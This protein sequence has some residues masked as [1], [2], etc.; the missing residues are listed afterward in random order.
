MTS[1]LLTGLVGYWK[2]DETSGP[3]INDEVGINDGQVYNATINQTGKIGKA[4]S[5]DGSGDYIRCATQ[6]WV[7]TGNFSITAWINITSFGTETTVS[8]I[9]TSGTETTNAGI[10]FYCYGDGKL[11]CDLANSAG[12]VSTSTLSTGTWYLVGVTNNGGTFQLYINGSAD[13]S[14]TSKSPNIASGYQRFG[15]DVATGSNYINGLIDEVGVWSKALTPTEFTELYNLGTGI[16]YP[17][18]TITTI[19]VSTP[20]D[21]PGAGTYSSTQSVTLSCATSGASIYYTTDGSTP[22]ATKTLYTGAFNISVTTTLKA[23]GIKSGY[24]NSSILSSVYTISVAT[25]NRYSKIDVVLYKVVWTNISGS[26]Q[27][28]IT[29]YLLDHN[30][31]EGLNIENNKINLNFNLIKDVQLNTGEL[32]PFFANTVTGKSELSTDGILNIYIKY[33]DGNNDD[34]I[35]NSDNLIKTYYI[36]DWE[37]SEPDNIVTISAV[38]LKYKIINR[39]LSKYYSELYSEDSGFTATAGTTTLTD[40]GKSFPLPNLGAYQDGLYYKTLELTDNSGNIYNYLIINNTAT[41]VTTHKNI[42][43]PSGGGWA[44]YRIGWSSPSSLYDVLT[45]TSMAID[46]SGESNIQINLN[47]VLTTGSDYVG[48]IQFLRKIGATT[49][50]FPIISI[51]ESNFPVYKLIDELSS[52]SACNNSDELTSIPPINRDMIFG[53]VWNDYLSLTDVNWFY[54][55]A[56]EIVS[57]NLSITN[58]SANTITVSSG[59]SND[60]GKIARVKFIRSNIT[61]YK[62]YTI[63]DVTGNDYTLDS[64]PVI[65]GIL[66]GDTVST[67][68]SVDFIWDNDEDFKH[69]LN[70]QLGSK[71]EE[72]YNHIIFNAGRNEVAEIDILG[73][74]YN[75]ETTSETI[76]D[77]FIPMTQI[78]KSMMNW[79]TTGTNGTKKVI[80]LNNDTWEGWDSGASAFTATANDWDFTTTFGTDIIYT[81]NSRASF[82]DNF[83]TA[84]RLIATNISKTIALNQKEN[85]LKGTIKVRGQRFIRLSSGSTNNQWYQKG[86]RIMFKRPQSALSNDGN[87]HYN[88]VVTDVKHTIDSSSWTTTLTVEYDKYNITE[89]L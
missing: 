81:I 31:S 49:E 84:A 29:N 57:D 67:Y 10:K 4:V 6:S 8:N 3:Y 79:V 42:D 69:I 82:N 47:R 60:E 86:T 89:I 53:I 33:A 7:G 68:G 40:S 14:S 48:G 13:G 59:T 2:L 87:T 26:T 61:Y 58:V 44:N 74:W 12:P 30:S 63:I 43:S 17:F 56:P 41:T 83:K 64:N 35:I 19:T 71:D 23:I 51:G 39:N 34:N 1:T 70:L 5:F 78:S 24:T 25:I 73:H 62:S 46:G 18:D 52:I 28:D 65:D 37:I 55:A 50:A 88:M 77:T 22:N 54:C 11:H 32:A 85:T 38:D 21:S 66:S 80:Q 76:K 72:R 75:E 16:T 45:R 20:T 27:L 9:F 36:T 15:R